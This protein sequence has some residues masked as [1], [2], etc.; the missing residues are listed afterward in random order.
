M[1]GHAFSEVKHKLEILVIHATAYCSMRNKQSLQILFD[2]FFQPLRV[3]FF[4]DT[5]LSVVLY[6]LKV[7]LEMKTLLCQD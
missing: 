5:L 7:S 4:N 2:F 3:L 1:G 6:F